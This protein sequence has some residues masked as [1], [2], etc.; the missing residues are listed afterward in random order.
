MTQNAQNINSGPAT[1]KHGQIQKI[2]VIRPIFDAESD[3][4]KIFPKF[5]TFTLSRNNI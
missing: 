1:R 4:N 3:G 2:L 5:E